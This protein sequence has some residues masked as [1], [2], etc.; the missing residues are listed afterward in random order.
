MRAISAAST[1]PK[2]ENTLSLTLRKESRT[3]KF[4]ARTIPLSFNE[5]IYDNNKALSSNAHGT[6]P[7]TTGIRELDQV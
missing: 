5:E 6:R 3:P 1:D 7:D 2:V 4:P